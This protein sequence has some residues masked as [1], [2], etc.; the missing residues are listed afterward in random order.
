MAAD[1]THVQ[2]QFN[3][4][5]IPDGENVTNMVLALTYDRAIGSDGT[6]AGFPNSSL[7]ANGLGSIALEDICLDDCKEMQWYQDNLDASKTY[8][9]FMAQRIYS[10]GTDIA[11]F[12]F[13]AEEPASSDWD[14]TTVSE[15]STTVIDEQTY[16]QIGT[17]EELAWFAGLINDTLPGV[18]QNTEANAVLT[19]DIDL[20]SQAWTP[21][22]GTSEETAFSGDFNGGGFKLLNLNITTDEDKYG[23]FAYN[24]GTI[25]NPD[26]RKRD[27]QPHPAVILALSYLIITGL[28]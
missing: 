6:N 28:S 14:G 5:G 4:S 21:I 26:D 18:V 25:R 3:D 17:A 9:G 12:I 24:T 11:Y 27:A 10:G 2:V 1:A 15:P 13:E 23:L 7:G 20:N 16:Y 19:A 8:Y 22:G